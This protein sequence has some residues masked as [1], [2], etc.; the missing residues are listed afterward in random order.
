MITKR[1]GNDWENHSGA[2]T[3]NPEEVC[4]SGSGQCGMFTRTH[5]DGWTITGK[6][7][8]DYYYW[9]NEFWAE[10]PTLGKVWGDYEHEVVA[11]SEEAFNDFYAKHP[12]HA[13][14]YGD[15]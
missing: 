11:D 1:C 4:E 3:L 10:H 12:P 13:W 14:D 2:L 8:E 7:V 5:A 9:V 6:V 15:I